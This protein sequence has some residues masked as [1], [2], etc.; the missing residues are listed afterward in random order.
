VGTGQVPPHDLDP[1]EMQLV[2]D[3][4]LK[5]ADTWIRR[6][7]NHPSILFWDITDHKDPA[8]C[9]PLL[10]KVKE[11]DPTRIAEVSFDYQKADA[12]LVELIDCYRLFGSLEHIEASISAIRTSTEL[13][14]KPVRVGEAGI[15]ASGT[16]NPDEQPPLMRGWWEFLTGLR[17]RNIHGLQTFYL[18]DM[19]YRGFTSQ[20][21]GTLTAPVEPQI[22]WPSQ[23]GR[24]ARIDP[25]SAGT[26]AALGKARLQLNWCDPQWPVSRPTL[27]HQWSR[28]LFRRLA[29]R[30]VGPLASQRIPEVIVHVE[31]H[32]E[33]LTGAQVFVEALA[34][35]AVLPFGVQADTRGTS[36]FT[37]PEPGLYRFTCGATS[38]E[39]E[40][41]CQPVQAPP[42]YDHIQHVRL[43]LDGGEQR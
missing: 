7:R 24:D 16:W 32:G 5:V 34:G 14:L 22:S 10:R 15:F 23:S 25:F 9:V 8:F 19:D 33:S 42:G 39:V 12:E 18:V 20:V 40:T 29:G 27:T 41:R 30:D 43:E 2:L 37:L 28:D 35:Q 38:V 6:S 26:Q 1:A 17:Q 3:N 11:L 4:H 21:P 13:P 36:W 31:R